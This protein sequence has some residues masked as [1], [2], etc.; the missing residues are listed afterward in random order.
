M[1][2]NAERADAQ[3]EEVARYRVFTGPVADN[4]ASLV[5]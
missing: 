3:L 2:T 4:S 5:P 1:A